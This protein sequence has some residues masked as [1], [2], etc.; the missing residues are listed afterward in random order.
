MTASRKVFDS[1]LIIAISV[2]FVNS[3]PTFSLVIL[4]SHQYEL[5]VKQTKLL[6]QRMQFVFL[7]PSK[8]SFID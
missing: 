8:D 4:S 5:T 2:A 6:G 1:V 3:H 7:F